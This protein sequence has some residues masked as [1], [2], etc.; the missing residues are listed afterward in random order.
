MP[1]QRMRE[2]TEFGQR[3]YDAR[4]AAGLSQTELAKRIGLTQGTIGELEVVGSGSSKTT[5]LALTCGVRIEWLA[6]GT[7][8]MRDT[9]PK[10]SKEVLALAV[11]IDAL[12]EPDRSAVIRLV[13]SAIEI[14]GEGP[15][16]R[17]K[18]S[19]G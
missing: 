5:E 9:T 18:V 10:I 1:R 2:R 16:Q 15:S 4:T 3:L 8:P 19:N 6:S 17:P 12:P 14:A 7:G 11:S 13:R